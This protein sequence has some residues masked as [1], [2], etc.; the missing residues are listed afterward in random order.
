MNFGTGW[1]AARLP[2]LGELVEEIVLVLDL[3]PDP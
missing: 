1:S 3:L 2:V